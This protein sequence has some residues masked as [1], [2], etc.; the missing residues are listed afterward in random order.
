MIALSLLSLAVGLI[1]AIL[2]TRQ[3]RLSIEQ[4]SVNRL[5]HIGVTFIAA[6]A[7]FTLFLIFGVV[8]IVDCF[9]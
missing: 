2:I 9:I 6:C 5:A 4:A 7:G 1:G 3:M 8:A